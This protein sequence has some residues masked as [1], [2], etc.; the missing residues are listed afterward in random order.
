[1]DTIAFAVNYKII[2]KSFIHQNYSEIYSIEYLMSVKITR[3]KHIFKNN[4]TYFSDENVGVLNIF[5]GTVP[6][7]FPSLELF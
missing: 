6:S 4:Y 1:M 5:D 2:R 7:H 3:F